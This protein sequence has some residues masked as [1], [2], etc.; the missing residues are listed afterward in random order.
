MSENRG[1]TGV[2]ETRDLLQKKRNERQIAGLPALSDEEQQAV[3][4]SSK[5][6]EEG[7]F[8]SGVDKIDSSRKEQFLSGAISADDAAA[9]NRKKREP[10]TAIPQYDSSINSAYR[11]QMSLRKIRS[12]NKF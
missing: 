12:T 8:S 3:I 9:L 7:F 10:L 4:K 1:I 11:Q 2:K 5:S 6:K